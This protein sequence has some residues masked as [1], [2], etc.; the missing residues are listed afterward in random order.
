M[1]VYQRN[2]GID[3]QYLR[4]LQKNEDRVPG[5]CHWLTDD[6]TVCSSGEFHTSKVKPE[7]ALKGS[8]GESMQLDKRTVHY[9]FKMLAI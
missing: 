7:N 6:W 9:R 1:Q 4:P 8:L 3:Y 5:T 2:V